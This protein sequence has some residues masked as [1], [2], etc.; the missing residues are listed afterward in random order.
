MKRP[1]IEV[2]IEPADGSDAPDTA[3]LQPAE[4]TTDRLATSIEDPASRRAEPDAARYAPSRRRPDAQTP[5]AVLKRYTETT[6]TEMEIMEAGMPTPP[7]PANEPMDAI[8]RL[9]V[10][11]Q[12]R[13]A[14]VPDGHEGK[15]AL[16]VRLPGRGHVTWP[17]KPRTSARRGS[18][19]RDSS[20][21]CRRYP[22]RSPG[23]RR[24]GD[25]RS[26]ASTGA[27]A[28]PATRPGYGR[29]RDLGAAFDGQAE[30]IHRP[31]M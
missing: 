16:R 23:G 10:D 5:C 6:R 21:D 25:G 20:S 3:L 18:H 31:V 9:R 12:T 17:A 7:W 8:D 1:G 24:S 15:D 13:R 2:S 28:P 26:S 11:G 30:G 14:N 29:G 22:V 27:S 19:A 4:A